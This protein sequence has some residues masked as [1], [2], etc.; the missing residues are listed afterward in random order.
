MIA[1]PKPKIHHGILEVTF[2]TLV[3]RII[4]WHATRPIVISEILITAS[5]LNSGAAFS[6]PPNIEPSNLHA[7][8]KSAALKNTHVTFT[9]KKV[10]SANVK[11]EEVTVFQN[12]GAL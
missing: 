1:Q 6:D 2:K 9:R 3:L 4:Q 5:V 8:G 11:L 7:V 10:K 12:L